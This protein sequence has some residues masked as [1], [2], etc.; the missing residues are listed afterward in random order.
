[1]GVYYRRNWAAQALADRRA[2]DEHRRQPSAQP[3]RAARDRVH[4]GRNRPDRRRRKMGSEL[5][6]S[7]AGVVCPP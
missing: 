2:R 3:A 5:D 6:L 1:M 4:P 7:S